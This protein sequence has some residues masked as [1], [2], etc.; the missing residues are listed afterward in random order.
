MLFFY[1]L[2]PYTDPQSYIIPPNDS[3][4]IL[5]KYT[6]KGPMQKELFLLQCALEDTTQLE[7]YTDGSVID[8]GTEMVNASFAFVQTRYPIPQVEF[9]ATTENF[10]SSY[11][12][13]ILAVLTALLIIPKNCIV[14]FYIDNKAVTEYL[15][16][17]PDSP[18]LRNFFKEDSNI[19]WNTIK[20]IISTNNLTVKFIKIPAHSGIYWNEYVDKLAKSAHGSNQP[21]FQLRH[22]SLPDIKYFPC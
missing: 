17:H 1:N 11:K 19:Y 15:N 13:E 22:T 7:F 16:H 6:Y 2:L 14:T 20:D 10:L 5:L 3:D 8:F 4:N 9:K 12:T 18:S 21:L